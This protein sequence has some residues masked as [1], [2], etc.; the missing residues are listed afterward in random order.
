M[1]AVG[2]RSGTSFHNER[3]CSVAAYALRRGIAI[4]SDHTIN[5][6][7]VFELH[8]ALDQFATSLAIVPLYIW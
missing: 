1:L 4:V 5:L 2:Q 6:L 3:Q 8:L 7:L